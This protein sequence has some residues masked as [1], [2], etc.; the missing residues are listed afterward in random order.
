MAKFSIGTPHL[1]RHLPPER[2]FLLSFAALI[3]AGALLLWLP[4]SAPPGRPLAFLDALFSSASAVC[5]T[6]LAVVDIGGGLSRFGQGVTVVL[7]QVGG[8]GILTF[9]AVL[10]MM[11]GRGLATK[12]HD[13]LQSVFLNAPRRDLAGILRF[14]LGSTLAFEA[15]GTA[16]L[17]A[18]FSFD[19][20]PLEALYVA[21]YHAVSAFNNCGYALFSDS[22]AAYRG[23]WVVN[24]TVM[25][26]IV[27]GGIGFIVIYEV[28]ERFR[29]APRRMSLHTRFV[30]IATA[31]L[32]AVG[33]A[34][35]FLLERE[36]VL[37]GL[38][39][40]ER[41]LAS[42]FQSIT[43]RTAG[44]STVEVALLRNETLLIIMLLMFV[45]GSPGSTAG[46]V[47]TTAVSLLF[48]LL[49]SR[50][51]GREEVTVF[52]R[53]VPRELL[54]RMVSILLAATLAVVLVAS[55]L[56]MAAP[57]KAGAPPDRGQF[58]TYLFETVSAFGTVGLSMN[59][60]PHLTAI[61]KLAVILMMIAG[62]VGPLT[63]AFSLARATGRK[64]VVYAEEGIMVG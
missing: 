30:L 22:L 60:T 50:L 16:V 41:L 46:G 27:G 5:V 53:T 10:F 36:G 49:W 28:A 63:L 26:L 6:G 48:V 23:D 3:L 58:I 64:Q 37:R 29:G 51:R 13:I 32:I 40:H 8:L 45:G 47:K 9:S 61:Q 25:A 2:L 52:N 54:N 42:L 21:L 15:A 62:R 31:A 38:A 11:M 57:D 18:R 14:V 44:F 12:E 4:A 17:W 7:F 20:P 55:I 39:F 33:A 1:S 43:S 59:A 35:F 24:L 34:A 19:F 56:L